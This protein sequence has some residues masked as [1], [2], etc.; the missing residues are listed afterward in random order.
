MPTRRIILKS[1]SAAA[2]A[3][4]VAPNDAKTMDDLCDERARQLGEA[5]RAK[6]GGEWVV[7]LNHEVKTAVVFQA[8]SP[9]L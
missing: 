5:M 4:F 6:H 1:I 7:R 3:H 8:K 2:I 9:S